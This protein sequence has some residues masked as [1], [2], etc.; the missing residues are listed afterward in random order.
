MTD[1]I[2]EMI[3]RGR[4]LIPPYMWG[5]VERYMVRRVPP[6]DFLTAL[7][8]NDLMEAFG[9]ADDENAANMRRY[10]QFLYNYAPCGSYGSRDAVRN[11]LNAEKG[12]GE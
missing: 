9:R 1:E 12:M 3:E 11:W 10:C 4:H 8:A 5:G 2:R 7:F 6:G